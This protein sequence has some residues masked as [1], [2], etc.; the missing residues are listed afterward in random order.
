MTVEIRAASSP[1]EMRVALLRDGLLHDYTLWR[2]GAPDGVGDIHRGRVVRH[3]PAMAGAFV[4][5]A[6][7]EGFLPDSEG[8]KGLTEGTILPVRITRSAQGG[9]GPRLSARVADVPS[10]D[11]VGLIRRGPDAIARFAA[12][13][14][15]APIIVD[16]MGLMASLRPR[17][18]DRLRREAPV[19]D[20][21]LLAEIEALTEPVVLLPSGA[22]LAIYPTPALTAIDVDAGSALPGDGGRVGRHVDLNRAV[23][24]EL[25]RQIRL[26]NL[27]GAIVIDLAGLPIRRRAALGP[28]IE[29]ALAEDPL[30][31]RFLGFTGLGLAEVL[32][33][34]VHPPLHELLAGP[35]A[36]G[37]A[38]LRAVAAELAATPGR[39]PTLRA[40]PPVVAALQADAVALNDLARRSGRVLSL[41]SDPSMRPDEWRMEAPDG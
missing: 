28:A 24:P 19:F 31:P 41:I 7:A 20:D 32:R 34:R 10:G 9:K 18:G 40:A 35:H 12:L 14:Q 15:E 27:S 39:Q 5:L 21:A 37:L 38:A 16:D 17:F 2:P 8:A 26:R 4:A 33:P 3:I 1:G 23:I 6:G 13:A 30:R 36:A 22:R 29:A 25:A 11:G